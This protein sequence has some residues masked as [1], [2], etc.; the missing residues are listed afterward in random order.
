MRR[1]YGCVFFSFYTDMYYVNVL[2]NHH[3][4]FQHDISRVMSRLMY[5]ARYMQSH[6]NVLCMI[7]DTTIFSF[8][9]NLILNIK[10][11]KL[12]QF[13]IFNLSKNWLLMANVESNQY[14]IFNLNWILNFKV[15]SP[16]FF[17][18]SGFNFQFLILIWKLKIDYFCVFFNF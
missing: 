11:W 14:S 8:I 15:E 1:W 12:I 3:Y 16:T 4:V 2:L 7:H 6:A 5:Y 9:E 18:V 10:N 17:K 13:S